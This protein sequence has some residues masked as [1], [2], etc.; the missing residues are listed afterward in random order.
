MTDSMTATLD[1]PADGWSAPDARSTDIDPFDRM[2]L[3]ADG[4]VTTLLEACTGEPIVTGTT[5]LAGPATLDRLLAAVGRWW[6]P[7]SRLLGLLPRERLIV[8]RVTLRGACSGVAYVSAESLVAPERLPE[9]IGDRL[10]RQGASLGR[11]IATRQL[12]T[13]RQLV[14]IVG[15]RAGAVGDRLGVRPGA[16]LARRTYTIVVGGRTVAA[17]TEWLAPGRLATMRP[18]TASP[19]RRLER[20]LELVWILQRDA[21]DPQ[22]NADTEHVGVAGRIEV[23]ADDAVGR[24][25]DQPHATPATASASRERNAGTDVA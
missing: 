8:R 15:V 23:D 16:Q 22:R 19:L 13:R 5:R 4:T 14:E 17:V 1:E 24:S 6:H 20:E 9:E 18:A 10:Q 7:D 21:E 25:V 11:L 3:A 2:L 12:E